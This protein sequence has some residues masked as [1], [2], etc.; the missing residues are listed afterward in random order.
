[1]LFF[2]SLD[3]PVLPAAL[4]RLSRVRYVPHQTAPPVDCVRAVAEVSGTARQN[5]AFRGHTFFL[6]LLSVTED[7][8][9]TF[10]V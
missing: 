9:H 3:S 5:S 4:G 1:M 8:K 10:Q 6:F 2:G 7:D